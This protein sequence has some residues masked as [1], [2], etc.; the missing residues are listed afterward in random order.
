MVTSGRRMLRLY[1]QVTPRDATPCDADDLVN[2]FVVPEARGPRRLGEAG[3]H[4]RVGDDAGERVQLDDVGD[5]EAIDPHIHAAPVTAADG[6]IGV[7]R[8][9]LDL[10]IERRRDVGGAL[11]DVER[12][13][14]GVSHPFCLIAIDRRGARRKDGEVEANHRETAHVCAV[15]EDRH[16]ELRTGEIGLDEYRLGVPL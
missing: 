1:Q 16:G 3:V 5:A 13:L 10:P 12:L 7:E 9:L 6:A 15:A 4:R 11:E 8:D 2:Q 14:G